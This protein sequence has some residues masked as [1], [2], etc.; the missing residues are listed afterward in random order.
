[1]IKNTKELVEHIRQNMIEKYGAYV[2]EY[3][4]EYRLK[5]LGKH[6]V[7]V[8]AWQEKWG[9]AVN[10]IE[11]VCVMSKNA[12]R[13]NEIALYDSISDR[14]EASR[15]DKFLYPTSKVYKNYEKRF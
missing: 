1:M 8:A 9:S 3:P 14:E 11:F 10:N 15:L 13:E 7:L 4:L 12:L 6:K 5:W 2:S